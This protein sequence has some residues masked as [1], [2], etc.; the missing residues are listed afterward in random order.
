MSLKIEKSE[1]RKKNAELEA[2]VLALEAELRELKENKPAG[3]VAHKVIK[4]SQRRWERLHGD[5]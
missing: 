3:V 4:V 1:T 2:R 5:W